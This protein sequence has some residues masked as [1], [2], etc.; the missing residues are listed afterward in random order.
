MVEWLLRDLRKMCMALIK[1]VYMHLYITY[2]VI[3]FLYSYDNKSVIWVLKD[4]KLSNNK[5]P[6]SKATCVPL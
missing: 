1:S 4:A 5:L 3:F 6:Q 2:D